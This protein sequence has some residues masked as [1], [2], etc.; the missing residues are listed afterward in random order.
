MAKPNKP[1]WHPRRRKWRFRVNGVEYWADHIAED[2]IAGAWSHL[3]SLKSGVVPIAQ[4]AGFTLRQIGEVYIADMD[5][6][7]RAGQISESHFK[8]TRGQLALFF[9]DCGE[10]KAKNL[11]ARIVNDFTAARLKDQ[12][13]SEIYLRHVL[14]A[15]STMLTWATIADPA[16]T[17]RVFLDAVPIKFDSR[18]GGVHRPVPPK[19]NRYIRPKTIRAFLRGCWADARGQ[20]RKDFR[21]DNRLAI[22]LLWFLWHTGARPKEACCLLWSDVDWDEGV[23]TLSPLRHKTGK[24]TGRERTVYL[25]APVERLLRCIERSGVR[26]D[27]HVFG[28]SKGPWNS[29]A[30]AKRVRSWRQRIAHEKHVVPYAARHAYCTE[31]L[32]A[33]A[34]YSDLA[35]LVGNSPAVLEKHYDHQVQDHLT[36][37]ASEVQV[38]RRAANASRGAS[39]KR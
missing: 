28:H 32:I 9:R 23:I 35:K 26:L 12:S 34:S 24:R 2:D 18:M 11:T 38:L 4:P 25:T 31:S 17:P 7:W 13:H 30:L 29:T 6:R 3:Q 27:G 10:V 21:R 37:R 19:V 5:R 16:R 22:L 33:G 1:H 20:H 36:H 39:R 15:V 14:T 8:T